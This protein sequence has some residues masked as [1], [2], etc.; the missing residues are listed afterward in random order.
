MTSMGLFDNIEKA[1]IKKMMKS[2]AKQPL[3]VV[4]LVLFISRKKPPKKT[5]IRDESYWRTLGG[6]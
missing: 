2:S 3:I 1:L 6:L 4:L 5:P